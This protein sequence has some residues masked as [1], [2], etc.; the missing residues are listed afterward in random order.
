[1]SAYLK[2]SML[3]TKLDDFDLSGSSLDSWNDYL[4]Q[5]ERLDLD[6]MGFCASIEGATSLGCCDISADHPYGNAKDN[7]T[8]FKR[9][10]AHKQV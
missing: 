10:E 7:T 3:I 8:C 6:P 9:I 2:P 5:N 1:M 4:L